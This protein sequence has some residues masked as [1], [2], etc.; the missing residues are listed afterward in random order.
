MR[1][2]QLSAVDVPKGGL[3]DIGHCFDIPHP[4]H[5]I[6]IYTEQISLA[7]LRMFIGPIPERQE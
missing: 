2:R 1:W 6:T 3:Q 4:R 5:V 7:G